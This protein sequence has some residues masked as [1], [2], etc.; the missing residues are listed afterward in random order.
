ME[1]W[2]W[3]VIKPYYSDY[4]LSSFSDWHPAI[5]A[6]MSYA[7]S[8]LDGIRRREAKV[9]DP[10]WIDGLRPLPTLYTAIVGYIGF[11]LQE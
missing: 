9:S 3:P 4:C 1:L 11:A 8:F 6:G 7:I 5:G 10:G 2:A